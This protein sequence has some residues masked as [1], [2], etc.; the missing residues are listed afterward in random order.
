MTK[1]ERNQLLV[2]LHVEDRNTL[3][4]VGALLGISRERVRQVV[5]AAGVSV[6]V[7][8]AVKYERRARWM[9]CEACGEKVRKSSRGR[10]CSQRCAGEGRRHTDDFLLEQMRR[11]ALTLDRTPAMGDFGDLAVAP[12]LSQRSQRTRSSLSR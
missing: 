10:F 5:R 4:E 11:L 1:T 3:S 6:D 7:T 12:T 9:I 8:D 2:R